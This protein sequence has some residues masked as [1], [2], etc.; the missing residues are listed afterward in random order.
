MGEVDEDTQELTKMDGMVGE[1][2]AVQS[3]VEAAMQAAV[4]MQVETLVASTIEL[5]RRRWIR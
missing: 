2:E 3:V 1:E 4:M 5:W